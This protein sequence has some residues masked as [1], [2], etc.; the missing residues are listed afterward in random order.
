MARVVDVLVF[1]KL[2]N[3]IEAL[4]PL[5]NIQFATAAANEY[6]SPRFS[7]YKDEVAVS[8]ESFP[9]WLAEP[10]QIVKQL[11]P[12]DAHFKHVKWIQRFFILFVFFTTF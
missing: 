8:L 5:S 9:I 10:A 1:S 2:P 6:V 4:Q 11:Q 12:V 3:I 7:L